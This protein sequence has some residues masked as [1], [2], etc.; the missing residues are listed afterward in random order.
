MFRKLV[1]GGLFAVLATNAHSATNRPEGYVTCSV[2]SNVKVAC[3]ASGK[4]MTA[5]EP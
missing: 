4:F 2:G 5:T 1:V 3:C